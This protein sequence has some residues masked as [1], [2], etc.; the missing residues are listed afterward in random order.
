MQP[1]RPQPQRAPLMRTTMWPSSPAV[2]RPVH[3]RPSSTSPPPMPVPQKTPSSVR[4]SRAAPISNSAFV[5][6]S[7][8]LPSETGTLRSFSSALRRLNEP[9]QPDRFIAP[10]TVPLASSTLPGAPTPTPA[11]S[12]VASPASSS[13]S[14]S[15]SAIRAAIAFG[16]PFSGVWSRLAPRTLWPAPSSTTAAWI[17]VPP[18]S[19]PPQSAIGRECAGLGAD[20]SRFARAGLRSRSLDDPAP[21][22]ASVPA[23]EVQ[24]AARAGHGPR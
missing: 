19:I 9:A 2:R 15:T 16:P 11:R 6:R 18:R 7:T 3:G 14:R 8:S 17:F 20:A 1:R 4:Y 24:A 22:R 10:E 23:G 5:A 12:E 13:A 21:G